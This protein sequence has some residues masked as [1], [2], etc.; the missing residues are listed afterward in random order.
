LL[1]KPVEE[2]VRKLA[3]HLP[4]IERVARSRDSQAVQEQFSSLE[5]TQSSLQ[6]H[7]FKDAPQLIR[8]CILVCNL[9]VSMWKFHFQVIS[10]HGREFRG[11]ML[12]LTALL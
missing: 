4:E 2:A 12:K 11:I 5:E 7:Q 3:A 10:S 8:Y 6:P 1:D 9:V